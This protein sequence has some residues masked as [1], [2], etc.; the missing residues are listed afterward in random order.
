[1]ST[2]KRKRSRTSYTTTPQQKHSASS[3]SHL[4]HKARLKTHIAVPP[5]ANPSLDTFLQ[6]H[7][8]STLLLKHTPH[9]TIVSFSNFNPLSGQ[10]R[11]LDECPFSWSWFEG[12]IVLFSPKVGQRIRISPQERRALTG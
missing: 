3:Q 11:I 4:F 7:L 2:L 10:G 9:G 8:T 1:M 12:D 6:T 5:A